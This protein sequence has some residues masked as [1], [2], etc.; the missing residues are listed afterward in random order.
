[1]RHCVRLGSTVYL[2]GLAKLLY[3]HEDL[4]QPLFGIPPGVSWTG[5]TNQLEPG[6][7]AQVSSSTTPG[8]MEPLVSVG[9]IFPQLPGLISIGRL[10]I[11]G[12]TRGINH[13]HHQLSEIDS[14]PGGFKKNT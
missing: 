5:G 8:Y 13:W 10:T 14:S 12:D 1:M 3:G 9:R 2:P 11:H 7:H 4:R 6:E